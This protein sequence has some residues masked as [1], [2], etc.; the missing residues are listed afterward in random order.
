M[1]GTNRFDLRGRIASKRLAPGRYTLSARAVDAAGNRS[2][3]VRRTF[4][5]KR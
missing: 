2:A 3:A 5:I 1:L 4:R